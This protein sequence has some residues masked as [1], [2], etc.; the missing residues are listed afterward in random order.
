MRK[1]LFETVYYPTGEVKGIFECVDGKLSKATGYHKTGEVYEV[2]EYADGEISK[3]TLYH[4]NGELEKEVEFV[5]GEALKTTEYPATIETEY[6]V[7]ESWM[8]GLWKWA[9]DNNISDETLPRNRD[10]LLN[11][12]DIFIGWGQ[13]LTELPKEIGNLTNL[14]WLGLGL[15][16]TNSPNCLKK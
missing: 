6:P 7:D 16:A 5:N 13:Q 4:R 15:K 12:T 3:G 14:A 10:G 11:L 8:K 9:D 1:P 2:D